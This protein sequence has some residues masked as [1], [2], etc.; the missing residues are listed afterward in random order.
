MNNTCQ[1]YSVLY[2]VTPP[3]VDYNITML[4]EPRKTDTNIILN[5][6]LSHSTIDKD[7]TCY[8]LRT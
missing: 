1:R 4:E 8:F 6:Y 7:T 5:L 2:L 3:I